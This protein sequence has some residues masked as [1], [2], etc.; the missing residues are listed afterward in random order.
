MAFLTND[1]RFR[2]LKLHPLEALKVGIGVP[3]TKP[4]TTLGTAQAAPNKVAHDNNVIF[5]QNA[6]TLAQYPRP[7]PNTVHYVFID[8]CLQFGPHLALRTL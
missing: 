2:D 5:I 1:V 4:R 7:I 3:V 8:Q 6:A